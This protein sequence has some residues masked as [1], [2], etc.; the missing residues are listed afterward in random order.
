[1][2]RIIFLLITYFA[3][4]IQLLVAQPGTVSS[5]IEITGQ[6]QGWAYSFGNAVSE[7]GDLNGDGTPDIAVGNQNFFQLFPVKKSLLKRS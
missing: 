1:M 4:S 6:A 3:A 5:D 7:L 2:N